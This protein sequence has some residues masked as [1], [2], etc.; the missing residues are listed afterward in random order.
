MR[1]CRDWKKCARHTQ[2]Q[3]QSSLGEGY[4]VSRRRSWFPHAAHDSFLELARRPSVVIDAGDLI[5]SHL[6][7]L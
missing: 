2:Q 4:D 7:L 6:P 1:L 5:D 3:S